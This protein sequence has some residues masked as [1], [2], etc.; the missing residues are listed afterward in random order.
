MTATRTSSRQ[1]AQKAKEA[2]TSTVEPRGQGTAGTKRK[3]ATEKASGPKRGKKGGQEPKKELEESKEEVDQ[4]TKKEEPP[5]PS[6]DE[7]KVREEEEEKKNEEEPSKT[8]AEAEEKPAEEDKK[9]S[10]GTEAGVGKSKERE[11][12]VS[13]N[14]L[15]KGIIYFFYRPRVNVEEPHS[16]KEVARSFVVL[17]PT[18]IGA[19]IDEKQGS[20]EP[21]A[22]CRLIVLPKKKFP[23]SA[24]ER[25]MAFVEKSGQSMKELRESFIAGGKYETSTRGERTVEEARPY[26]EGVYAIT[27]T[28]RASHLAYIIT[29]PDELGSVQD[30]FGLRGRGSWIVQAK[31]PKY[32]GPATAQLPKNPEY[33]EEIREKFADY[34]WVPLEPVFINYPNAQILMIGEAQGELG[35][36]VIAEPDGKKENEEQPGEELEKLEHENEERIEA[37]QGDATVY[38]DLGLDAKNYPPVPT[39]WD[40]HS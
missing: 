35:K 4:K 29:I 18:P 1:A 8:G 28:K 32:P 5:K 37:L 3:G 27:S 17:R 33:P 26:A 31:N 15:E 14:V 23:T 16:M 6:H 36:A 9:P 19:T 12:I 30:D 7:E 11:D 24:R 20:L 22:N 2:I 34:R 39:T 13:S 10:D 21:G 38:Q 25:D 40:D